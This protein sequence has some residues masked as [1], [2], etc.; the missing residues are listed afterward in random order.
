MDAG[1]AGVFRAAL[2]TILK[3]FAH[4]TFFTQPILPIH[5]ASRTEFELRIRIEEKVCALRAHGTS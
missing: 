1:A 5:A 3:V 2:A 4:E